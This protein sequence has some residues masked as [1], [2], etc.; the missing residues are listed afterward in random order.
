[1]TLSSLELELDI[2]R[3]IALKLRAD[4]FGGLVQYEYSQ[5]F[6]EGGCGPASDKL[7]LRL[8][9]VGYEGVKYVYG[10]RGDSSHG[11]LEYKG[12]IIDITADQFPEFKKESVLIIKKEKSSL[13]KEFK[14]ELGI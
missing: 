4:I 10:W 8:I 9:G 1:M 6:P 5:C 11:W 3:E 2:I 14:P 7:K 12:F 13:H